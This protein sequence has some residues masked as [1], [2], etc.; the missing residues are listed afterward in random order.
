LQQWEAARLETDLSG[1]QFFF[2]GDARH[3]SLLPKGVNKDLVKRFELFSDELDALHGPPSDEEEAVYDPV[4]E[5]RRDAAALATALIQHRPVVLSL[6]QR[7]RGQTKKDHA[8]P[9]LCGFLRRCG[10]ESHLVDSGSVSALRDYFQPIFARS[11]LSELV[12][13]LRREGLELAVIH[14]VAPR[15]LVIPAGDGDN[16]RYGEEFAPALAGEGR[17]PTWF[18]E[19]QAYWWKYA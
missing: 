5:C 13:D 12:W 4:Y 2:V 9:L 11:G 19:A 7:V 8:E 3:E 14:I 18:G 17:V 15:A 1:L 10:I 6:C 16:D